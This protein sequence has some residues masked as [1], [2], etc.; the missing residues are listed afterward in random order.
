MKKISKR[1]SELQNYINSSVQYSV[2]DGLKLLQTSKRVKFIE[3]VDV[4]IN[5]GIDARKSE[6]NV[7][8]NVI[9]PYGSGRKV[10]IAVFAQGDNIKLAQLEGADLVGLEDLCDFIKKEGCKSF[11]VIIAS[12]DVMHVVSKLGSILGPRGLMP[13]PKLGTVSQ[14]IVETVKNIKLGQ[15]S[16]KNDKNGVIH[17]VIGRI[18]FNINHLQEN[19]EVLIKSIK[20]VKPVQCKGTY[21]KKIFVST[22]MGKSIVIDKSSLHSS[23]F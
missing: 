17:S 16:Y 20:Q 1:M 9:L 12:P 5:L 18:N 22:T 13:N 8:G 21:I 14:N 11:D 19:L 6:Q 15:I 4:A 7:R 10:R 3:S 2:L 23:L